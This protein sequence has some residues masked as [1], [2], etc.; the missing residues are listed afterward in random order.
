MYIT[1]VH[2]GAFLQSDLQKQIYIYIYIYIHIYILIVI[3]V[4]DHYMRKGRRE[5]MIKTKHSRLIYFMLI[6]GKL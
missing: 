6:L 5:K 4:Q 1:F 2:S 3:D